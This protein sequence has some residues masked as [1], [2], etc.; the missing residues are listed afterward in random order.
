MVGALDDIDCV[1]L[2]VAQMFDRTP[3]G[4]GAAAEG[5]ARIEPL[6]MEPDAPGLGEGNPMRGLA[7]LPSN[8][9]EF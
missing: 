5:R 1:D 9:R 6:R 2:H 7:H 3:G 8:L 4:V